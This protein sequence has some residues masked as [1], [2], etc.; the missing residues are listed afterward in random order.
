MLLNKKLDNA[1]ARKLAKENFSISENVDLKFD[2]FKLGSH[3][4]NSKYL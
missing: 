3:M 1:Q 2:L 4:Q